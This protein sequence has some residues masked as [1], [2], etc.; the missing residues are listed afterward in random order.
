MFYSVVLKC[1]C[2]YCGV[3]FRKRRSV[4]FC[5]AVP[6]STGGSSDAPLTESITTRTFVLTDRTAP[7][8][9]V[10]V[11]V[12]SQSGS[13]VIEQEPLSLGGDEIGREMAE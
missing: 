6:I 7:R 3:V 1:L 11:C 9:C 8:R 5:G 2:V 4:L 13:N 12:R 10:C